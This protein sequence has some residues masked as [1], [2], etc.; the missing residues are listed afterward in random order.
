MEELVNKVSQSGLIEFDLEDYYDTSER[1]LVDLKDYLTSLPVGDSEA[2]ILQEKPFRAKIAQL[3]L[4]QFRNK[5]VA[6]SCSVDAIIPTWA[7]MLLSI[8]LSAEAK[9]VVLGDLFF[10]ENILFN[11][12]LNKI[13]LEKFTNAK[14][15]IK[16]CN[17]FQVPTN[18][19]VQLSF[20]LK[21]I[22]KSLMYGEPCSTVPLYKQPK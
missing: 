17:K 22:V 21:P 11:E 3:D 7:Y 18:A 2:F 5:L 16:G 20:L 8:S 1:V 4:Q 15:V 19:Y 6:I 10:L 14:V 9:K 13:E 12:A